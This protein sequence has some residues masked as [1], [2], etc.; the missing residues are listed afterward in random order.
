MELI[1]SQ[2]VIVSSNNKP[3]EK[4]YFQ[5]DPEISSSILL[6]IQIPNTSAINGELSG[7]FEYYNQSISSFPSASKSSPFFITLCNYKGEELHKNLVPSTFFVGA[8][9]GQ[10]RKMFY[11]NIDLRQ[12]YIQFNQTPFTTIIPPVFQ[13]AGVI[14]NFL[15]KRPDVKY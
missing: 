11:N 13:K 15:I 6:G 5:Q 2:M 12:S 10:F 14:F 7:F 4:L 1:K 3:S 9:N 8:N